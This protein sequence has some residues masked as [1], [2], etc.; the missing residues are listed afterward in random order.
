M[1][2][3]DKLPAATPDDLPYSKTREWSQ[4]KHLRLYQYANTFGTGIKNKFQ[5]R[6][7]IDLYAGAGKAVVQETGEL[8]LGSPL[9]ALSIRDRFTKY[10][11]CGRARRSVRPCANDADG[12]IP[13]PMSSCFRGRLSNLSLP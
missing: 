11:L 4:Q 10:I 5:N 7:Y 12:N 8:V 1:E 6:V 2:I 9:L 13:M 3:F